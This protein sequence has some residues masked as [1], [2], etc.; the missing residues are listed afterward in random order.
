MSF[1]NEGKEEEDEEE[2]ESD[3]LNDSDNIDSQ[4]NGGSN[5]GKAVFPL[6]LP[7][8]L[9]QWS[10]GL[11]SHPTY[12]DNEMMKKLLLCS[13]NCQEDGNG[14]AHGDDD[15]EEVDS[16]DA[17]VIVEFHQENSHPL[18]SLCRQVETLENLNFNYDVIV[19]F[20]K[21]GKATTLGQSKSIYNYCRDPGLTGCQS[22]QSDPC[23]NARVSIWLSLFFQSKQSI[24][25]IRYISAWEVVNKEMN[26]G[27]AV[28]YYT[29]S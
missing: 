13:N 18:K 15:N 14:A 17:D 26:N 7:W 28:C 12:Q 27:S 6:R 3:T 10:S 9:I 23:W 1:E 19:K 24:A 8:I 25:M 4:H 21:Q 11:V 29:T 2:D 16:D 5:N 22:L 20:V